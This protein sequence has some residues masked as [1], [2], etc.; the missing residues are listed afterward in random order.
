MTPIEHYRKAEKLLGEGAAVVSRIGQLADERRQI[1]AGDPD[2]LF[3]TRCMDELGKKAMGVWAQAQVHATLATAVGRGRY[4][5]D[6]RRE[7]LSGAGPL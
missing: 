2:Y 7:S 1:A 6:P 4:T 5:V 3:V